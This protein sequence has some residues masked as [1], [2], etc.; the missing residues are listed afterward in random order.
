MVHLQIIL[1]SKLKVQKNPTKSLLLGVI[2]TLGTLDHRLVPTM[3]G[4]DSL[5]YSKLLGS[6][7]R[8]VSDQKG[9]SDSSLG[10]DKNGEEQKMVPTNIFKDISMKSTT[11]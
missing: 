2:S 4:E 11:I 1:F 9:L 6:S 3:T 8:T 10:V 7:L 5:L